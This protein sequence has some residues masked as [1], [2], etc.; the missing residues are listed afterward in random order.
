MPGRIIPIVTNQVYHVYNRGIDRRCTFQTKKAYERA[1]ETLQYYQYTRP[2]FRL[3]Y[4]LTMS[5]Q[6]RT[7]FL[8]Q[9]SGNAKIV[10]ILA[11]CL[12]PN[13]FHLLL[14]QNTDEGISRF[15]SQ[16][17]NSYTKYF[18]VRARRIGSLFLD[19]FKAVRVESDD[20]LIHVSRYIHLNPFSSYIVKNQ[21]AVLSYPWSSMQS[22][23]QEDGICDQSMV[24][25]HFKTVKKYKSFVL[26]NADYQRNLDE[27]KHLIQEI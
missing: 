19:Q 17:Q 23:M 24:R 27:I 15:V 1:L 14:K 4:Y 25:S 16:F 7:D 18:N 12:M 3:S 9:L 21:D 20:M 22:Y 6:R 10:D 26:D 13:H 11:Y 5:I 2:S 8:K